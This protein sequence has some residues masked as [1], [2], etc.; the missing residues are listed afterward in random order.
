VV[1]RVLEEISSIFSALKF[2]WCL[3]FALLTDFVDHKKT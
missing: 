3:S 2:N 1:V